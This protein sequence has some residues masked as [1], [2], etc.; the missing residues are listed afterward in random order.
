VTL[1][2]PWFLALALLLPF[3]LLRRRRRAVLFAPAPLA[4]GLPKSWRVRLRR[5]PPALGAAGLLL[6]LLALARPV[7][8][9]PMPRTSEGL[10][11][12]LCLD[13]SSSMDERDLDADRTRLE[14]AK[15]AARAFIERRPHD[16]V[17]LVGFARFPDLRCPPTSDHAALLRILDDT[18]L[19]RGDGPEDATGIGTAVARAAAVLQGGVVI[20]LTDGDENVAAANAPE[21][22]APV[23]AGQLA[24]ELGVRVY[25][26]TVGSGRRAATGAWTPLDTR[27]LEKLAAQTGG[28]FFSARDAE[29][30]ANVYAEIDDLETVEFDEPRYEI[31]ERFL[32][33]LLAALGLLV[34]GRLLQLTALGVVP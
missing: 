2:H 33:Y 15:A 12:V 10:D 16:R 4:R 22:I 7:E 14:V 5:L 3:A 30:V 11:I 25:A 28:R 9:V 17:G 19:V 21:E 32:P 8:R 1:L 34:A 29:A 18:G 23:H 20:L 6:A 31:V 27:Q 26:L 13:L 24:R